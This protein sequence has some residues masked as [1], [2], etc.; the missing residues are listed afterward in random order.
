MKK[1]LIIVFILFVNIHPSFAEKY[2]A[3]NVQAVLSE[4][5]HIE[6]I[7][8]EGNEYEKD[9]NLG[10]MQIRSIEPL[11]ETCYKLS[12]TPFTV[13]INTNLAEPIQVTAKFENCCSSCGRY[14][15]DNEDLFVTPSS[16]TIIALRR[17]LYGSTQHVIP[18]V[19]HAGTGFCIE[20]QRMDNT[21]S[22]R[23][24]QCHHLQHPL[25]F[26]DL[27]PHG[28]RLFQCISHRTYPLCIYCHGNRLPAWKAIIR[29]YR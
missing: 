25:P 22:K 20:N 1:N 29:I 6:K 9:D 26:S 8:V 3:Q 17:K 13:R 2:A 19:L 21:R 11:S 12:L 24:C 28:N 7:I 14:P 10:N 15:M 5:L 16:Y 27:Q 23:R 4:V 18:G